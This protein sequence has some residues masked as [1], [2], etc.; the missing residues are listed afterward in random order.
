MSKHKS[1]IVLWRNLLKEMIPKIPENDRNKLS[2]P[3]VMSKFN[4]LK[5]KFKQQ[6]FSLEKDTTI[7]QQKFPYYDKMN[8]IFTDFAMRKLNETNPLNETT[9]EDLQL[10]M[11]RVLEGDFEDTPDDHRYTNA[12]ESKC[13]LIKNK[14]KDLPVDS[15]CIQKGKLQIDPNTPFNRNVSQ[16]VTQQQR[17]S[18]MNSYESSQLISKRKLDYGPD[19]LQSTKILKSQPKIMKKINS[20]DVYE[21]ESVYIIEALD[22]CELSNIS[23]RHSKVI[24]RDKSSIGFR[25]QSHS[26]QL[27][28]VN[29]SQTKSKIVFTPQNESQNNIT[30]TN[31]NQNQSTQE[32][33]AHSI[34]DL[35][36][37]NMDYTKEYGHV[38]PNKSDYSY[39]QDE[40]RNDQG[41][42]SSC[43]EGPS[44]ISKDTSANNV[45]NETIKGNKIPI[46]PKNLLK[47]VQNFSDS[48]N[49]SLM[50]KLR[51]NPEISII[52]KE[53]SKPPEWF[54]SFL[55]KY[56][57]DM[58]NINNKLDEILS[59]S[60]RSPM[61]QHPKVAQLRN[62]LL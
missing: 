25:N 31:S 14:I 39:F 40:F 59:R 49:N 13:D 33:T 43:Y 29:K 22:E 18:L 42:E 46:V 17:T 54:K 47:E 58:N 4:S 12:S 44:I 55:V 26:L 2:L 7:I 3:K 30:I 6:Y 24:Y 10:M 36:E 45:Y 41:N 38:I 48:T 16:R 1:P 27:K 57:R 15:V 32:S 34:L 50:E 5:Q 56:E 19:S 52:T 9:Y 21:D 20:T 37:I 8:S 28:D 23:M 53:N 61:L 62:R 60:P 51:S 35:P 11:S